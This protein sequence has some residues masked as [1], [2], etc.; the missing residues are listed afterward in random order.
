MESSSQNMFFWESTSTEREFGP[1]FYTF[2]VGVLRVKSISW[3]LVG[4]HDIFLITDKTGFQL[5]EQ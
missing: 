2:A 1:R 5:Q 3:F 4:L